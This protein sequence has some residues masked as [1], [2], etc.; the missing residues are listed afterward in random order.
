MPL[1]T[2]YVNLKDNM[3]KHGH[4]NKG[5][6]SRYK[7]FVENDIKI[8]MCEKKDCIWYDENCVCSCENPDYLKCKKSNYKAEYETKA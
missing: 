8:V 2:N 4:H 5:K 1:G 6:C 7:T 3:K